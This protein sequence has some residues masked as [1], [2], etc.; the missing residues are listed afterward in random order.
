MKIVFV[1]GVDTTPGMED[2]EQSIYENLIAILTGATNM[3]QEQS[4]VTSRL[5]TDDDF[6]EWWKEHGII[7]VDRLVE[8]D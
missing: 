1:V 4:Y 8:G 7:V 2:V 5:A 3:I 6:Q